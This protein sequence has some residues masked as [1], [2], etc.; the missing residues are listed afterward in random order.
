M[1]IL[2]SAA[3][4]CPVCRQRVPAAYIM[5][6]ANLV[7]L[8]QMC[9]EHGSRITD[10]WRGGGFLEWCG[11]W[12][13]NPDHQP[14]C[15]SDCGLCEKHRNQ[16]CCA[17]LDITKRCNLSCPYCFADGGE[18]KDLPYDEV[19]R[20]LDQ[21]FDKGIRFLH[22]SGGEP[23]VHP[24]LLEIIAYAVKKGF[25]YIQLNT[26]GIRI[27]ENAQYAY[28]LA[29][30][31]LSSVFLQF[32]GRSDEIYRQTRNENLFEIKERAIQYCGQA[33]LGV[34]LVPT[35]IPGINDMEIGNIIRYA[36][37]HA[38]AVRGVHF[39]PVTYTG[40][41]TKGDH[42]TMPQILE[43]I[44]EQTKGFV[45]K[46]DFLPS[47]CDAPLCGFHAEYQKEEG[48]LVLLE[49]CEDG[50]CCGSGSD[51]LRN[52][53]HVKNRWTRVKSGD[54]REDSFEAQM[55]EMSDKSFCISGML[56]QDV[57]NIDLGRV[58]NCSL[59]VFRDGK[60]IPFCVYHNQ[61]GR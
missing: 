49:N 44:E 11:S 29:D 3:S 57:E 58:M 35:V 19:C 16:T 2:F 21:M 53:L 36:Y 32:D 47:A 31:G 39:Q 17:L 20:N 59:H 14:D 46:T 8:K 27:A 28:A 18:G 45:K 22:L 50:C 34:M 48:R 6:K 60:V 1:K 15:P 5:P 42:F 41:F 38:P 43:A 56:F 23:T 54:Y 55:K 12:R 7:Q 30:A 4:V 10:V 9:P 61:L 24:E 40:R 37:D 51:L 13:P 25:Y 52:Q 26:N 33:E